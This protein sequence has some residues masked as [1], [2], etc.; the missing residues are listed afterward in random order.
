MVFEAF[1]KDL[2]SMESLVA[3]AAIVFAFPAFWY[4]LEWASLES[5]FA[6]LFVTAVYPPWYYRE[7]RRT[8]ES[9]LLGILFG[10]G[11]AAGIYLAYLLCYDVIVRVIDPG[12]TAE[13]VAFVVISALVFGLGY[14]EHKYVLTDD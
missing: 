9:R 7:S 13:A 8:I 11:L 2:F 12:I 14:Y 6:L 4:G 3:I 5:G 1:R 10:V